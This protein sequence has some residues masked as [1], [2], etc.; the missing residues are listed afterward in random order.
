MAV[1]VK[2]GGYLFRPQESLVERKNKQMAE[3]P[4]EVG[5]D[6]NEQA[7]VLGTDRT[8]HYNPLH[9]YESVWWI[10]ADPKEPPMRRRKGHGMQCTRTA[11]QHWV[12]AQ[13]GT[14]VGCYRECFDLSVLLWW[15]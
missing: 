3:L 5:D 14:P 2:R 6:V 1:E 12:Q 9:D 8:F 15:R 7:A 10:G 11:I 13:S 4:A